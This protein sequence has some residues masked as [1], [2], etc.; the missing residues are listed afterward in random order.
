MGETQFGP[1]DLSAAPAGS[2]FGDL[3]VVEIVDLF[4]LALVRRKAAALLIVPREERSVVRYEQGGANID[5][6]AVDCELADALVARLAIIAGLDLAASREQVGRLRVAARESGGASRGVELLLLVWRAAGGL[7]AEVRRIAGARA[8]AS[9]AAG[10]PGTLPAGTEFGRYRITGLLGRGGQGAVYRAEHVVLEKPVAIKV[11]HRNVARNP[12]L[13]AQFVIEARAACRARHPA[14]IDVSDFGTLPDGRSYYVM[15][16]VEAITLSALLAREGPLAPARVLAIGGQVIDALCAAAAQGVVHCDLKPDNIFVDEQGRVRLG[17]FGL[18]QM[19]QFDIE[20]HVNVGAIVGTVHYM[21]PEL[22]GGLRPDVR[23]DIY[24]VGC[25][26]FQMLTGR[27]PF[28]GGSPWEVLRLHAEEPIPDLLAPDG[29]MP[30]AVEGL[31]R[32]AMAKDPLAR[33]QRPEEMLADLRVAQ[34]LVDRGGWRRW[35]PP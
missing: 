9:L 13:A 15:E 11:L 21:A 4:L 14:I 19:L 3:G 20:E 7:A 6:A 33:Y 8:T 27:V 24:A 17:D 10:L 31:V 18:A 2:P 16:L 26:L 1:T 34:R 25:I 5:L 29:A 30:A 32:R 35:L 23:S 12:A 22:M 28:T